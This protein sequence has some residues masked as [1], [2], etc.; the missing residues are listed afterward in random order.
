MQKDMQEGLNNL[1]AYANYYGDARGINKDRYP[2]DR[3][4]LFKICIQFI[5]NQ[6]IN[7]IVHH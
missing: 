7:Y 4:W 5:H 6:I 2:K 1:W 3:V